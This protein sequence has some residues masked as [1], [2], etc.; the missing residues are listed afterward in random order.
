MTRLALIRNN[1]IIDEF[2]N[3]TNLTIQ[4]IQQKYL[5]TIVVEIPQQTVV[6]IGESVN[7]FHKDWSRKTDKE[8]LAENIISIKNDEILDGNNIRKMTLEEKVNKGLIQRQHGY[9]AVYNIWVLLSDKE[10]LEYNEITI[11]EYVE[12]QSQKKRLER[13]GLLNSTDFYMIEDYPVHD[14][15]KQ[16]YKDYRQYLR[17]FTKQENFYDI[18]IK[19]FEEWKENH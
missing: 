13:N 15:L 8:L 6:N 19:S 11:D 3:D 9:K 16:L 14:D 1:I 2:I 10:K 12:Q 7:Y 17:D 18:D 5:N 4:Q